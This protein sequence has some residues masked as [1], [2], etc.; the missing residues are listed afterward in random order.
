MD[1]L[2]FVDLF[3]GFI[4][5][6]SWKN[7]GGRSVIIVNDFHSGILFFHGFLGEKLEK[8]VII[9][10]D[11]LSGIVFLLNHFG[12]KLE[13]YGKKSV[14]IVNDFLSGILFLHRYF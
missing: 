7:Q 13:I 2:L 14:I 12:E 1:L 9:V 8:S 10:N 6:K 5:E 11:F 3:C 4:A